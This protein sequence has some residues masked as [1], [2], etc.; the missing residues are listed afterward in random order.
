MKTI[1]IVNQKSGIAVRWGSTI[2]RLARQSGCQLIRVDTVNELRD[3][4]WRIVNDDC[5]R[6]IIGGGDGSISCAL[7]T[8]APEFSRTELAIL[9][10]GTGNDLARS[11]GINTDD[12]EIAW[13]QVTESQ[14]VALDVVRVLNGTETYFMNAAN[15][16]LG[17]K[18]AADVNSDDKRRWGPFAYWMTAVSWLVELPEFQIQLELDQETVDLKSHGLAIAN[19]RFIGGGFPIAP[20][21]WLNDGL[22]DITAIP[23]LP[24]LELLAAGLDFRLGRNHR[25]VGVQTYRSRRVRVR[26]VPEIPFSVDG[27]PTK[28]LEAVFEVLPRA[29]RFA[30]GDSPV[31]VT[32]DAEQSLVV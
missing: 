32:R 17:G 14:T 1:A 12:C 22:L 11:L 25:E 15:G 8:L 24:T 27:E 21:A 13:R 4:V 28:T 9:P 5:D 18:V 30:I 23:V 2:E 29:V 26:G 16:G 6:L 7:N 10:L 20:T 3:S 31:A 19:G